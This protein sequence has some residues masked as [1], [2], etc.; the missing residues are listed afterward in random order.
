MGMMGMTVLALGAESL[1]A[2]MRIVYG[3]GRA[4]GRDVRLRQ[5]WR[6]KKFFQAAILS[7]AAMLVAQRL[8]GPGLG[9][10]RFWDLVGTY[11]ILSVIDWKCQEVPDTILFCFFAGQVLL[12]TADTGWWAVW[13]TM[14][15]GLVFSVLILLFAWCSKGQFGMG[16][17]KLLC[18]TAIAAGWMY[19]VQILCLAFFLSFL[20]SI[21]LLAFRKSPKKTQF[22]FVP[23]LFAGVLIHVFVR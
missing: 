15:Y 3:T 16:D 8:S 22:P 14:A 23:F 18:V 11:F 10:I 6:E 5:M 1:L 19:V 17:A 13:E 20:Y 21:W 12:G 4:A 2:G 9:I 7:L